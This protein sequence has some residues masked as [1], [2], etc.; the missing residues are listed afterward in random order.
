MPLEKERKQWEEQATL[1][2]VAIGIKLVAETISEVPCLWVRRESSSQQGIVLYLHGGGLT[3]GSILTHRNFVAKLALK[4]GLSYLIVGYRLLPE[5]SFPAPL[6]DVLAVYKSLLADKE[7][8]SAKIIIAGDSSGGGLALSTLTQLRDLNLSMPAAGF[9][10]SGAF[11]MTLSG[12]TMKSNAGKEDFLSFED[13]E[14]WQRTYF[15]DFANPLLSPLFADLTDLPPLLLLAGEN[16]LWLSDSLRLN[17]KIKS[18]GGSV[19]LRTWKGMT[20]VWVMNENLIESKD[21][22]Q[23][24][25]TFLLA[26]IHQHPTH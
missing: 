17:D 15:D 1:E 5:H 2:P 22:I 11:D 12:E 7:I 21:S 23:V 3:S 18:N 16:E 14:K 8:S 13:L 26:H 4:T 6:E 20:H 25:R 19:E 9:M 10:I 24:I